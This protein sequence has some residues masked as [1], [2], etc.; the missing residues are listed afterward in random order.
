MD[1]ETNAATDNETLNG[2]V[3]QGETPNPPETGETPATGNQSPDDLAK[4]VERLKASLRRANVEAKTHRQKSEELDRIKSEQLTEAEKLQK[5]LADLQS[6]HDEYV[7]TQVE[8]E[9]HSKVGIE[10]A[11]LGVNPNH[12]DKVA[13]FLDWEE[14]ET[15]DTGHPTNIRDLVE[16]LVKDMPELRG[17]GTTP[18]T[19]GGATNPQR[20]TTT[21]PAA[22]SWEVISAMKPDE[23]A[24]RGKE[25]AA[26]ISAHP[27]QYGRKLT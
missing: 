27:F 21:A 4:E 1:N 22:L 12:L 23:Y 7:K 8:T 5:Q 10:A 17:K 6:Q 19:S 20:S 14:I 13:R 26:W 24:A 2:A 9:I 25:I 16:Q 15:D 11:K 3:L 18:P